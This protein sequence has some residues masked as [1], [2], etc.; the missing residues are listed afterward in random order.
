MYRI[1]VQDGGGV[2]PMS[3]ENT[4]LKMDSEKIKDV[5]RHHSELTQQIHKQVIDIRK[6]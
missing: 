4:F 6:K 5:L 2:V 1:S 3:D